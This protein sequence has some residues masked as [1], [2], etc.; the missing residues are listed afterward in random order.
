MKMENEN[1]MESQEIFELVGKFEEAIEKFMNVVKN[2]VKKIKAKLD[3]LLKRLDLELNV[4]NME[5]DVA[6][7]STLD[8]KV[9]IVKLCKLVLKLI[10]EWLKMRLD[11][12]YTRWFKPLVDICKNRIKVWA[13]DHIGFLYGILAKIIEV[14]RSFFGKVR[15]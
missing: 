4:E 12:T 9:K 2:I 3:D 11:I 8:L 5:L 15:K 13:N 10:I 6:E 14:I 1:V 7:D